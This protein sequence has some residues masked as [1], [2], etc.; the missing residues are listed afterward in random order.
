MFSHAL[1][2]RVIF[3]VFM[4]PFI[5]AMN[6]ETTMVTPGR[7]SAGNWKQRDFP[8]PVG[9]RA[10]TSRP[11]R[12]SRMIASCKGRKAVKPKCSLSKE[13]KE[14][15]VEAVCVEMGMGTTR[16]VCRSSQNMANRIS[17]PVVRCLAHLGRQLIINDK[18]LFPFP[19]Y[20]F[21][22]FL[23]VAHHDEISYLEKVAGRCHVEGV[24][25]IAPKGNLRKF[26]E[27]GKNFLVWPKKQENDGE[28]CM[29]LN[30]SNMTH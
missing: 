4:M 11:A 6:G 14:I 30:V 18:R 9:R 25:K 10:R 13:S 20:F 19:G 12:T 26:R 8:P 2:K 3:S 29:S 15:W 22:F 17:V 1:G 5:R 16:R 24:G 21:P 28:L 7:A 23:I 27:M